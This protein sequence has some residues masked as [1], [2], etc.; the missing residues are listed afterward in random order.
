MVLSQIIKPEVNNQFEQ[1][2][3][4]IEQFPQVHPNI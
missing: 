4:D 3:K 1:L 2:N